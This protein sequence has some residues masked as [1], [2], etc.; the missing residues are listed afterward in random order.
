MRLTV[1]RIGRAHGLKGEVSVEL[2]TDIP[3]D[4]LVPGEVFETEPASAGPLTVSR[5]R[6]QAGRWYVQFAEIG[7]RD[8]AE[9]ARGVE[10]TL[11]GA[12]SDEDDAWYVHQ[13]VGLA[14]VRPDGASVGEVV[15]LL[16][17]PAQ[18]VL[19]VK[20]PNGH[21]AMI[22]FVE[23]FV[24]EVDLD[25]GRVVLTPPYGLLAGEEPESTGETAG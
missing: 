1:A 17:M 7:D 2:R 16:S 11:D 3:D 21:R 19:V 20:E 24:P 13:L 14:A 23:E 6:V 15:D 9:A 22:P 12:E 10:L 8:A 25:G 4:R 18:D 5:V